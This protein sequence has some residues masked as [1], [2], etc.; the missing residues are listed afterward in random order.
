MGEGHQKLQTPSKVNKSWGCNVQHGDI[1]TDLILLCFALLHFA[2]TVLLLR[3]FFL[4][5]FFLSFFLSF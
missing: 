4:F 1:Q 2:D 3:G 5:L